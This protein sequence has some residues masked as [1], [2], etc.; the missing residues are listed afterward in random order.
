M[1]CGDEI[2]TTVRV[3]SWYA[4]CR[5]GDGVESCVGVSAPYCTVEL[6]TRL[7]CYCLLK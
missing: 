5:G 7:R 1:K 4:E 6:Y 2:G 3:A